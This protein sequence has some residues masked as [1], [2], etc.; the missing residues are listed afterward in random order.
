LE[1]ADSVEQGGQ[2]LAFFLGQG[3]VAGDELL[4]EM[5][6]IVAADGEA[7]PGP[8]LAALQVVLGE[9]LLDRLADLP[10]LFAVAGELLV[11]VED[12]VVRAGEG[13]MNV[14]QQVL[15]A[16]PLEIESQLQRGEAGLVDLFEAGEL[17]EG[18]AAEELFVGLQ[19]PAE[20]VADG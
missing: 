9:E 10:D 7:V 20:E 13:G 1:L 18:E 14:A 5:A 2:L 15:D 6:L 11:E 16:L 3:A 17:I 12:G 4:D 8:D 19:G